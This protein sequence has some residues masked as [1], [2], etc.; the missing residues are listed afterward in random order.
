LKELLRP[1]VACV[2]KNVFSMFNPRKIYKFSSI[3]KL[4]KI[5]YDKYESFVSLPV[6]TVLPKY[7]MGCLNKNG[8]NM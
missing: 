2:I 6:I 1:N 4:Y 8:S 7:D 3:K 5:L